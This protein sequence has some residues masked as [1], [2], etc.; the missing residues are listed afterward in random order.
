MPK[1]NIKM[2]I[3]A[4]ITKLLNEKTTGLEIE[5]KQYELSLPTIIERNKQLNE[6]K[7]Q[8]ASLRIENLNLDEEDKNQRLTKDLNLTIALAAPNLYEKEQAKTEIERSLQIINRMSE[9]GTARKQRKNEVQEN[10]KS[11]EAEI[12]RFL[13]E[14][15]EN[16]VPN[17]LQIASI[18][19][20]IE[21]LK[22]YV[23]TLNG[24]KQESFL[25]QRKI[26][27]KSTIT[28]EDIL[29]FLKNNH[30]FVFQDNRMPITYDEE[31]LKRI[32]KE[33]ET[34][35]KPL[36]DEIIARI[37]FENGLTTSTNSQ[38]PIEGDHGTPGASHLTRRLER[39]SQALTKN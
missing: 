5:L 28:S 24:F 12:E 14:I 4:E 26:K 17:Y 15:N 19:L 27:R 9:R 34:E 23:I 32:I 13:S 38:L 25:E 7:I 35:L 2:D 10:I 29:T 16:Q 11:V 39:K 21:L 6:L 37:N 1:N 3:I 18:V 30:Y 20:K 33:L 22:D 36:M 31:L 8:L